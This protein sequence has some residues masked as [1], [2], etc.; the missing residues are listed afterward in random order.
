[1]DA[2]FDRT[3]L[4]VQRAKELRDKIISV[5]FENLTESEKQ[6]WLNGMKGSIKHTDMNRIESNLQTIS[7]KCGFGFVQK[8]DW[9][10]GDFPTIIDMQ[11]IYNNTRIVKESGFAWKNTNTMPIEPINS[12][13]KINS[14]EKILLDSF[15][16]AEFQ[17]INIEYID[18]IYDE[19]EIV[20]DDTYYPDNELSCDDDF[21][22]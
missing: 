3:L 5:K 15:E 11:R 18:E 19:T 16:F 22:I 17:D 6:E 20:G 14:I 9:V 1:M 8:T 13:S 4:D 10:R 2:V 7:D 21:I 12:Y